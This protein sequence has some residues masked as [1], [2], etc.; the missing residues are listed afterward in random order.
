MSSV[1]VVAGAAEGKIGTT[2]CS[3]L[4]SFRL[5]SFE[6]LVLLVLVIAVSTSPRLAGLALAQVSESLRLSEVHQELSEIIFGGVFIAWHT[7]AL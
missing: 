7:P 5:M 4:F 1:L 6:L 3:R 2:S